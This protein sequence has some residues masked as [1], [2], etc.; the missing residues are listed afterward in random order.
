MCDLS[1]LLEPNLSDSPSFTRGTEMP[2]SL[3][4]CDIILYGTHRLCLHE[5]GDELIG[6]TVVIQT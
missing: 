4:E 3:L 2:Q 6:L 5:P 1:F